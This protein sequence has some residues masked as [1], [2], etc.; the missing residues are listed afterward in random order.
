MK[1]IWWNKYIYILYYILY[2]IIT[3]ILFFI[4]VLFLF[5][6]LNLILLINKVFVVKLIFRLGIFYLTKKEREVKKMSPKSKM[7]IDY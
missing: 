1:Y 3:N 2:Y 6:W 7:N 4:I 5:F